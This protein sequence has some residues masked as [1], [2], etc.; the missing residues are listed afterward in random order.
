MN[1]LTVNVYAYVRPERLTAVNFKA[2][3][4]REGK[5]LQSNYDH[6]IALKDGYRVKFLIMVYKFRKVP[7]HPGQVE[8]LIDMIKRND[9][10]TYQGWIHHA[11]VYQ[12][13][14]GE[15][16]GN[17]KQYVSIDINL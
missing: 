7:D 3:W 12:K 8:K 2:A 10:K 4:Y 6:V 11:Q 14:P 13:K 9:K 17:H 16:I 1:Y 15:K 5:V